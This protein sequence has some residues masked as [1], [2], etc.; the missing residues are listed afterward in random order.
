MKVYTFKVDNYEFIMEVDKDDIS[1]Q[2]ATPE[3]FPFPADILYFK[4]DNGSS[5]IKDRSNCSL[6]DLAKEVAIPPKD[7]VKDLWWQEYKLSHKQQYLDEMTTALNKTFNS[8]FKITE[9]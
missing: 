3:S 1:I 8:N 6:G 5:P 2:V 9:E 7:K 4:N